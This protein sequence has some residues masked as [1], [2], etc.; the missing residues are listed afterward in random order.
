MRWAATIRRVLT[1]TL[2][3]TVV[4]WAEAGLALVDGDQ[5]MQCSMTAHGRSHGRRRAAPARVLAP[6]TSHGRPPC[7]SVSN[8]R[9]SLR[10]RGGL[11]TGKS[12]HSDAVAGLRNVA[13]AR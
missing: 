3:L 8:A 10:G 2:A 12:Q 13:V 5:A 11:E 7:C 6:A 4:L 9:S 1:A